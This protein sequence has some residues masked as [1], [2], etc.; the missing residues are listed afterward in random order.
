MG[1]NAPDQATLEQYRNAAE[2][3][4]R[5]YWAANGGSP[6]PD[7]FFPGYERGWNDAKAALSSGNDT[8]E[9]DDLANWAKTRAGETGQPEDSWEWEHGF[10]R[11]AADVKQAGSQ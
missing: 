10:K 1:F 6:N 4:H 11:G 2:K 3:E 5:D 7:S 8:P 9:G